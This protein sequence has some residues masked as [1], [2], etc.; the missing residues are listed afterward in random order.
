MGLSMSDTV[1][2]MR[3]KFSIPAACRERY[4][5]PGHPVMSGWQQSGVFFAGISDVIPGYHIVNPRPL[6][7][8]LIVTLGGRGWAATPAGTI[9]LEPG[10]LFIGVPNEPVG[11]G[12]D[13]THWRL[14][15]WYIHPTA[16]WRSLISAHGSLRQCP[17]AAL[18]GELQDQLITR[19]AGTS[20]RDHEIARLHADNLLLHLREIAGATA[21]TAD[22]DHFATVWQHVTRNLNEPWSVPTFAH[23]LGLSISSV[24]RE[25]KRRFGRSIHQEL[26][27]LRMTY[28]QQVLQQTDYPLAVIA[29]MVGCADPYTFSAAYRRWAG[30]SPS[31]ERHQ[32]KSRVP[33]TKRK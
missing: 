13:G 23:R 26:I 8:M 24:Q 16:Q 30:K 22:D 21:S 15:W 32:I 12:I 1:N 18:L 4:V 2:V 11:W 9:A 17:Q 3:K 25:A 27:A 7:L 6:D 31:A 10:S 33:T 14:V 5:P 20:D 29:E 19:L 28:A